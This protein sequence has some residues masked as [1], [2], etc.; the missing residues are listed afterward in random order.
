[1][2]LTSI[3]VQNEEVVYQKVENDGILAHGQ[4]GKVRV[5]NPV[6]AY[7]WDLIDGQTPVDEIVN[8]VKS[9]FF[10]Q[11]DSIHSDVIHY[12]QQLSERSLIYLKEE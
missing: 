3:P 11:Y 6:G 8:R 5:V 9:S 4:K 10:Y 1:M 7:I 2:N 12:L